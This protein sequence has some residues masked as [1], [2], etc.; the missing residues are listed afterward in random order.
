MTPLTAAADHAGIRTPALRSPAT[1]QKRP[2][3]DVG[4][5]VAGQVLGVAQCP[6]AAW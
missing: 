5:E 4:I 3:A 2:L 6:E 1:G